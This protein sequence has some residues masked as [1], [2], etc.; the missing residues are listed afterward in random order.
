LG[1][2]RNQIKWQRGFSQPVDH[3]TGVPLSLRLLLLFAITEFLLCLTPGP[4]VLLVISQAVKS[5]FDSSLKGAAGILAGNAIYFVLSALGLGA[6]L[7]SS[8]ILFQ[9]IKWAGAA[10]LVFIGL[11]MLLTKETATGDQPFVQTPK[12]ALRLFSEGLITQLSNPK[13]IVFFSALLPQFVSP[14]GSILEQ[15]AILGIVSLAIE[16]VV[17]VSY[18]W[19]AERG[20]RMILKGR[21]V[22]IT[23]RVAGGFLVCA[24]LGLAS[25]RRL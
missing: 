5:G 10:Y 9:I 24:G 11:R 18:G 22:L 25:T 15:F 7:M 23:D 13:A 8:A 17:L 3:P 1:T 2:A 19:A 20:S 12:R 14:D 6:L 4:A 21:F 16:L